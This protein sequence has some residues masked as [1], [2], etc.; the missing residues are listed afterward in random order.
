VWSPPSVF[1]KLP[2]PPVADRV[3]GCALNFPP[4]SS[5]GISELLLPQAA[6]PSAGL[7]PCNRLDP[8]KHVGHLSTTRILA[9]LVPIL[10]RRWPNIGPGSLNMAQQSRIC[11]NVAPNRIIQGRI[12]RSLL[13]FRCCVCCTALDRRSWPQAGLKVADLGPKMARSCP[14][15]ALNGF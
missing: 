5:S 15:K 6:A 12:F 2:P 7:P 9:H 4:S 3:A 8:P 13:I 14:K 10:A 11:P 1:D